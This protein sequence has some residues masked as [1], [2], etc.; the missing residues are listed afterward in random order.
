MRRR[1]TASWPGFDKAKREHSPSSPDTMPDTVSVGNYR[2]APDG[3]GY[4]LK[5]PNFQLELGL[6]GH[7]WAD[8][9]SHENWVRAYKCDP[10]LG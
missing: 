7:W 5:A 10:V 8:R 3:Y 1:L 6:M 9:Y 4:P 2:L